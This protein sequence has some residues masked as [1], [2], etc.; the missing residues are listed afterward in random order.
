VEKM[1]REPKNPEIIRKYW[2]EAQTRHR[3]KKKANNLK[4]IL[5][6]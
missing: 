3:D 2:R 4:E 5:K 6:S 1:T